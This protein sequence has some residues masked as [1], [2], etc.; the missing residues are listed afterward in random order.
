MLHW[1]YTGLYQVQNTEADA[2]SGCKKEFINIQRI[3]GQQSYSA[4]GEQM[5]GE[6]VKLAREE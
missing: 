4:R 2:A 3:C 6:A 5:Q 1:H